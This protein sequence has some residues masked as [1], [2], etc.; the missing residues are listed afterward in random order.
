MEIALRFPDTGFDPI[1]V[2]ILPDTY[3]RD[4]VQRVSD[5]HNIDSE[6]IDIVFEGEPLCID[7]LFMSCGTHGGLELDVVKKKWLR[8]CVDDLSDAARMRKV[9]AIFKSDPEMW[10]AIDVCSANG[11]FEVGSLPESVM[12]VFFSNGSTASAL[13][14]CF[15]DDSPHLTT[16]DISSFSN[17]EKIGDCFL[18]NCTNLE[19]VDLP[20]LSGI[21]VAP[22][23]FMG[24]SG[25]TSVDLSGLSNVTV[26]QDSFMQATSI[27]SLDL[28]AL[29]NLTSIQDSFLRNC[30]SLK[31]VNFCL[32]NLVTIGA[33]FMEACTQ[34]QEL[35][36][37]TSYRLVS[38]G[39]NFLRGSSVTKVVFPN[40]SELNHIGGS[41]L[42]NS[43]VT[44]VDLTGLSKLTSLDASFL[45]DCRLLNALDISGLTNVRYVGCGALTG[46][47]AF[48]DS[49]REL[50]KKKFTTS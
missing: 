1:S 25:V 15:L 42:R 11:T 16:V 36:L 44:Q 27:T 5:E 21:S 31:T 6:V 30:L 40:P 26:I 37:S 9:A 24:Q 43:S 10:F 12:R 17:L 23:M 20:T 48:T 18:A 29:F 38:I 14:D 47:P 49:E 46:S 4:V 28:S 8:F 32:P 50:L 2:T 41:F 3:V 22:F 7:S 45:R 33:S 39:D 19:Q 35:D 34:L 13:G